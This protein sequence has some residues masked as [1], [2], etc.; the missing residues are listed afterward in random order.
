MRSSGQK[1]PAVGG[2]SEARG[3]SGL[4]RRRL[5]RCAAIAGAEVLDEKHT[6]ELVG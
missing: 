4:E 2:A 5:R 3:P 1:V 6:A